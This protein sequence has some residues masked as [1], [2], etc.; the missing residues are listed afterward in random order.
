MTYCLGIALDD[1]LVM[2][3]DSRTNSGIDRIS[4]VRKMMVFEKPGER[5]LTL[6]SA[7]NLATTQAVGTLL[8][9]RLETG[10]ALDLYAAP[11]SFDAAR[12]VGDT[13]REVVARDG[14]AVRPYGNPDGTFLLGGEIAGDGHRL[15]EIYSAGNFIEAS[16][17][18]P[19]V[20]IGE[21]KYGKPIL[22][23]LIQP[24]VSLSHASKCA[25]LSMD[26]TFRSNLSAAPPID[27]FCY[28]AG[29]L[30]AKDVRHFEEYDP[31]WAELRD[32]YSGGL[33]ELF[34][35]LPDLPK[36]P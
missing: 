34:D 29:T 5:V 4:L 17:E 30:A 6:L 7:G 1:G 8:S 15:F 27:L 2:A 36:A 26:A 3:S 20:Q 18:M 24:A 19:F 28:R 9:Q 11:T 32:A 31:Y 12:V 21:T 33:S 14:E 22:D 25:L 35:Q 10:G 16:P 13:L 23:R